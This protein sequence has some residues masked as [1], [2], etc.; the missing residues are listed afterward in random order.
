MDRDY[1]DDRRF[2]PEDGSGV[3][4]ISA[5]DERSL[6]ALLDRIDRTLFKGGPKEAAAS[7]VLPLA[8]RKLHLHS[9][10]EGQ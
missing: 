8:R 5:P 9:D 10:W 3:L 4:V 1:L 7:L 6:A 2:P